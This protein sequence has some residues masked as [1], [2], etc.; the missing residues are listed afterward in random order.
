VNY[1]EFRNVLKFKN[2]IEFL[3]SQ[4]PNSQSMSIY[5]KTSDKSP[6]VYQYNCLFNFS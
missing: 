3:K 1:I 6:G 4:V 2:F 5:R